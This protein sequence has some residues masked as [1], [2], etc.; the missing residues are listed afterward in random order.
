MSALSRGAQVVRIDITARTAIASPARRH[1]GEIRGRSVLFALDGAL[2]PIAKM[3]L[4]S[5]PPVAR[6]LATAGPFPG[7]SSL[8]SGRE[9]PRPNARTRRLA[10]GIPVV[11]SSAL[12]YCSPR[13]LIVPVT[14]QKPQVYSKINTP[15]V[16]SEP[17][18][19]TPS[20][21]APS[22]VPGARHWLRPAGPDR[23]VWT[24][25]FPQ[26]SIIKVSHNLVN[27]VHRE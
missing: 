27:C 9:F 12:A 1:I 24:Q 2:P 6:V 21:N 26:C 20:G 14:P 22:I 13:N 3:D 4:A 7:R 18:C 15:L 16:A 10:T 25:L 23:N 19:Q 17:R 11:A 8:Q 5:K